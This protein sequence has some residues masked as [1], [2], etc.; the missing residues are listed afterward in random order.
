ML[1]LLSK[2]DVRAPP[3]S[4]QETLLA[5]TTTRT[6]CGVLDWKNFLKGALLKDGCSELFQSKVFLPLTGTDLTV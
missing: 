5:Y 1:L 3:A 2:E 4:A 6:N